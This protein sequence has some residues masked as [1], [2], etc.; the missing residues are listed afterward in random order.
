MSR[1]Y[2]RRARMVLFVIVFFQATGAVGPALAGDHRARRTAR[3]VVVTRAQPDCAPSTNTTLG[4]FRPTPYIMVRGNN[5]VGAGYSPV[6]DLWRWKHGPLRTILAA[7]RDDGTRPD[8]R[9]RLRWS[10]SPLGGDRVFLPESSGS[11]AGHLSDGSQQLLCAEAQ[12]N[13]PVSGQR[14]QLD[15]SELEQMKVRAMQDE[16]GWPAILRQQSSFSIMHRWRRAVGLRYG[17]RR[18]MDA[19]ERTWPDSA[20]SAGWIADFLPQPRRSLIPWARRTSE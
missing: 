19:T 16:S 7:P 15:R 1:E 3:P 13:A 20:T 17:G 9:S 10:D 2:C 4:I 5:P 14:D 6:G 8:V 12:P 18:L 11:V